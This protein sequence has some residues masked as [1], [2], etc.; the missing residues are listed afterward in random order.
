MHHFYLLMHSLNIIYAFV[1]QSWWIVCAAAVTTWQQI[2]NP[3]MHAKSNPIFS[4]KALIVWSTLG[5]G[6]AQSFSTHCTGQHTFAKTCLTLSPWCNLR[7]WLGVE[8]QYLSTHLTPRG[9]GG[10][11]NPRKLGRA[12]SFI[13]RYSHHQNGSAVQIG[14]DATPFWCMCMITLCRAKADNTLQGYQHKRHVL[15]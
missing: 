3:Q 1:S 7:G 4:F 11:Q 8:N 10:G 5:F 2:L 6:F 9:T 13:V 14:S 15:I 12:R